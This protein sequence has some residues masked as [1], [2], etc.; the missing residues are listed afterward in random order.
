MKVYKSLDF[1]SA[2]AR[3]EPNDPG[4]YQVHLEDYE[5]L[6][7]LIRRSIRTRSKFVPET[8]ENA[9]YDDFLSGEQTDIEDFLNSQNIEL[10]QPQDNKS[11]SS[12]SNAERSEGQEAKNPDDLAEAAL[13]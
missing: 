10:T 12:A 4:E 9:S 3:I 1:S 2:P 5:S 8:S 13:P 11:G 6:N 7:D